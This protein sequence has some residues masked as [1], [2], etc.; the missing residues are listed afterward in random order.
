MIP[1]SSAKYI[2]SKAS[3]G[4]RKAALVLAAVI[5]LSAAA[6]AEDTEDRD[7]EPLVPPGGSLYAY[8]PDNAPGVFFFPKEKA[9]WD[10]SRV[11][12]REWY[13]LTDVQK[14]KFI[15]EYFNELSSMYK[16]DTDIMGTDYLKAL[17]IFSSYSNDRTM[18]EPSTKFIDI[19]LNG[20]GK[21]IAKDR[22]KDALK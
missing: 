7:A 12:M 10:G 1:V 8:D 20:Q 15:S 19:L 3:N 6:R 21:M 5:L 18:R 4:V 9:R 13:M 22:A 11:T 2:R 17:N 16:V 14:A